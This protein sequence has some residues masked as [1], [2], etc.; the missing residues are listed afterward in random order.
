MKALRGV[1]GLYELSDLAAARV[2]RDEKSMISSR[3]DAP[4]RRAN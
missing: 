4:A 1:H 3:R 2:I